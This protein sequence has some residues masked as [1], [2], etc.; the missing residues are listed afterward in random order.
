MAVALVV[1]AAATVVGLAVGGAPERDVRFSVLTDVQP[2][3]PAV[4]ATTPPATVP[5]T[6]APPTA[7][8]TSSEGSSEVVYSDDQGVKVVNS[9]TATASTGGN[10]VVGPG[11]ASVVNGPVSAVGNSSEVRVDRP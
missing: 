7:P 4:V 1:V 9:G 5:E 3:L 6:P 8:K 10:T 11:S 2:T